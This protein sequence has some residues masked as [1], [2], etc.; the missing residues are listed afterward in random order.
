MIQG[1]IVNQKVRI[2][3][4]KAISSLHG[5]GF[6]TIKKG[7]LDLNLL[8][9]AHLI[10]KDKLEVSIELVKMK[11]VRMSFVDFLKLASKMEENFETERMVYNDLK[12]RGYPISLT[13]DFFET[14]RK[15]I[16]AF[17][18]NDI[19]DFSKIVRI[20]KKNK[21][22]VACIVDEERDITSY[23]LSLFRPHRPQKPP[24]KPATESK[25]NLLSTRVVS[26]DPFNDDFGISLGPFHELSL[27][28]A[29]YLIKK[30]RITVMDKNENED[31][32]EKKINEKDLFEIGKKKQKDF[33]LIYRGYESLRDLGYVPK[34]GFKYGTHFRVYDFSIDRIHAP[35]LAHC[36]PQKSRVRWS[37][38][39]RA[40]RLAHSVKK[41]ILFT[42][43]RDEI[44][45]IKC[46]RIKV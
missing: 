15:K 8:E 5:Q 37:E 32:D 46:E 45:Y 10:E 29:L 36:Y 20:L 3:D 9:A 28:E 27:I 6:G 33:E 17:S 16:K 21:N 2:Y 25:A 4:K 24:K 40:S 12:N 22:F 7:Y 39:S 38:I 30:D 31:E 41:K 14:G 11:T 19:F 1:R 13:K 43:V 35:Y 23:L 18:E 44:N 26:E 42:V 34:T